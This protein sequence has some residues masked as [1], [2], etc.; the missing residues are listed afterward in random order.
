MLR[1]APYYFTMM[2]YCHAIIA[3]ADIDAAFAIRHAT[4]RRLRRCFATLRFCYDMTLCHYA[5]LLSHMPM[6]PDAACHARDAAIV[7]SMPAAIRRR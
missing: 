2:R 4:C 3:A 1:Y 5:M 7:I 6:P